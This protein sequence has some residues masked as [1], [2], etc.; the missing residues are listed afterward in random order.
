MTSDYARARIHDALSRAGG[1]A[2]QAKRLV[3]QMAG[4]D[5]QLLAGLVRPFIKGIVASA[6]ERERGAAPMTAPR[7]QGQRQ[8]PPR[9]RPRTLSAD[10]LDAVIGRLG[11]Q[12]GKT[13][14]EPQG[15]VAALSHHEPTKAGS[16]HEDSIRAMARA[17]ARKR[18]DSE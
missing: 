12:V 2:S 4:R 14:S 13:T 10:D 8:A 7:P 18:F 3:L 5:P 11:Q 9:S 6:V 17:Y 1:D 16:K 15:I